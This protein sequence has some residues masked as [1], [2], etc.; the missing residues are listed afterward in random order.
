MASRRLQDSNRDNGGNF[1]GESVVTQ[2]CEPC[3]KTNVSKTAFFSARIVMNTC[4][5]RAK[6][7]HTV[8]K[9]GQHNIVNVQDN[10][11]A[12]IILDM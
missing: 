10:T 7:P 4:A 6:N 8:Y 3:M 5:I 11:S 2:S 12:P 1:V 9:P